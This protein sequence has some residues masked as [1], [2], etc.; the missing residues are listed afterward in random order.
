MN[1]ISK[2]VL[3]V[4]KG[5]WYRSQ[6]A[7]AIYN[8]LTNS[9]NADSVG[10]YVGV[11]DE[12]EGQVL[13]DL[14][15]TPDFFELMEKNGM[16]VRKN[17]T[18]RLQPSMIDEYDIVVSMAEEPYVPDF[19]KNAKKV[20]WWDNI[21]NPTFVDQKIAQDTYEKIDKLVRELIIQNEKF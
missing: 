18:K 16:S 13:S 20:V 12:P 1:Q 9:S 15:K 19:L 6:M 21:K 5:N 10:T 7:A 14:F 4:C 2:K 3:F 8:K 11:V 17:F